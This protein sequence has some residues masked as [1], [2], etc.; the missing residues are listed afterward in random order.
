MQVRVWEAHEAAGAEVW[1]ISS[2]EDA[3]RVRAYAESLGLTFPILIDETGAVDRMYDLAFAFPTGAY[4]Q[5]FVVGADGRI[6]YASNRPDV[7]AIEAAVEAELS[8]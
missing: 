5:D 4:P 7:E 1:G 6:V 2:R 3:A 8:P